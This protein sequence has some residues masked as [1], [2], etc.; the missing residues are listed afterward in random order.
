MSK[1]LIKQFIWGVLAILVATTMWLLLSGLGSLL[2][3][4]QQGAD[5]ASALNI[6]PNI[7]PDLHV[8][9]SWLP[10]DAD[11]ARKIEP[12]TRTQV[13]SAYLRAWL[14]WNISYQKKKPYGLKTYFSGPALEAIS[15]SIS[16]VAA[17][18]WQVEQVDTLH[19]LQLHLY[20]ADGS[21]ISFTDQEALVSQIIRDQTG[22]IVMTG[23]TN[24]S[25]DV[26]MFLEDGNWHIRHWLRTT[27]NANDS[28]RLDGRLAAPF[29]LQTPAGFVGR[30][31]A[32]NLT[33]GGNSYR[34]A[35]IN[36]Y[37]QATPWDKFWPNY[38]PDV[39]DQDFALIQSLKLNTIRIF[40]PFEQF[41]GAHLDKKM[42]AKLE[43]L[44]T[45]AAKHQLKVIATLFDFRTD[46]SLLLWP[47][48]DRQLEDLLTHFQD[49]PTLLAWDL[50]NEPD[51][52]YP[53][54]GSGV[55]EAWLDHVIGMARRY[56]QHH[57]L[58]IGWSSLQAA[59]ASDRNQLTQLDFISFHY[60]APASQLSNQYVALKALAPQKP[61][62]M[63]EFGLP[64]WNSFFFPNG[65]SEPE[66]A[67]YYADILNTLRSQESSGYLAWTLYDFSYVPTSVAGK[68]P[69]QNGPQQELG[70]FKSTNTASRN[71]KPAAALLAPD[72]ALNLTRT[73]S[74]ARFL[75]PFWLTVFAGLLGIGFV[76]WQTWEALR[77]KFNSLWLTV[78]LR[79]QPILRFALSETASRKRK[80]L[81]KTRHDIP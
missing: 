33:L 16:E 55:V 38:N 79:V 21:I 54:W 9:V 35:G 31:A 76:I 59:I 48:A 58:T 77:K 20:S 28:A 65:H 14:Q 43:D 63:T 47:N 80:D 26:V 61:L 56:D 81:E 62:V 15:N 75:K 36:Y 24:T 66:Q 60:F 25:Y 69:W 72:A 3:Y 34:V 68:L 23:E 22:A 50:K 30:N 39:T 12:F 1:I 73:P 5:P 74:W 64:T 17:K 11:T 53:V 44:L 13:E 19:R 27:S 18:G 7:P 51:L 46:Y 49:N 52:D 67:E 32:S 41:G 6:V 29:E 78:R 45:R 4:F 37:P 57:L 71:P 2:V 70:I 8:S 10:D 42:T 40:I